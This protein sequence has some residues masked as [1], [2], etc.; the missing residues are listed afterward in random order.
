MDPFELIICGDEQRRTGAVQ[1][2]RILRQ[3]FPS[4][5]PGWIQVMDHAGEVYVLNVCDGTVRAF[6]GTRVQEGEETLQWSSLLEL[7]EW[8][9]DE[10]QAIEK[11]SHFK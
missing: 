10:S 7:I 8:M 9:A 2:T 3:R 6:D 4:I 1:A 11:D 5:P